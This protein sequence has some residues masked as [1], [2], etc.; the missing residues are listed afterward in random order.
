MILIYKNAVFI[1][2]NVKNCGMIISMSITRTCIYFSFILSVIKTGKTFYPQQ[3]LP[4]LDESYDLY[5]QYKGS[6]LNMKNNLIAAV[7]HIEECSTYTIE[8]LLCTQCETF[9][10]LGIIL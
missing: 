5:K 4:C 1:S 3:T 10:S 7:T 6:N 8:F 2:N 9:F